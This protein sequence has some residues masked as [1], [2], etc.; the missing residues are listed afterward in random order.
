MTEQ[1]K[2]PTLRFPEFNQDWDKI[3]MRKIF[4]K[5]RNGFVG[6]ATPFYTKEGVKYLQ[7]KNIKRNSITSDG[8]IYITK[9]FHLSKPNSI[10]QENDVLMVQSGHVGEC[11]VVS[12]EYVNANC[13]A[14]LIATPNDKPNSK[15]Y[16]YYF[17]TDNGRRLLR[18]ITTGNTIKHI[19]SSDLKTINVPFP[20]LEEQQKISSFLTTVDTKTEQLTKKK[21][22][23]EQY[24]KGVMQQIFS[25][26][27]R[28][29]DDEGDDYPDWEEKKL[30]S[31]INDFIVPMRDK[32]KDLTGKIPWCR[33][34]DFNGKYL[35]ESK[36]NQGVSM[37]TVKSMNLKVYPVDT[38]LVSCSAYLGKCAIIKKELV[39]NQTFIGL[40]PDKQKINIEFL[41]YTMILSEH[42]LNTLSSGTTISYLSREEFENFKVLIPSNMEEQTKIA[43][44]LSAIDDKIELVN[45]QLENTQQFKKGL[46]QQMFV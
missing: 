4:P 43:N 19:L 35:S 9:E 17:Y 7:G 45:T 21:S 26:S 34:E 44:F 31:F 5:I 8:L 46:L 15:F 14:L 11:A 42:R 16:T 3:R 25:Q 1:N 29:K 13:H 39:T 10:L 33:I 6:V 20:K 22:L 12:K 30:N 37:S 28:F 36:S 23:L 24:K 2:I 27:I 40:V 18:K 38:L 32:P 41:F